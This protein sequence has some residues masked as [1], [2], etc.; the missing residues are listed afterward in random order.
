MEETEQTQTQRCILTQE[1][2]ES[3]FETPQ[4]KAVTIGINF[5]L[6][7]FKLI[8]AII[9]QR[10]QNKLA[11]LVR[12]WVEYRFEVVTLWVCISS[13]MQHLADHMHEWCL[14]TACGYTR[15]VN[16]QTHILSTYNVQSKLLNM[17]K[18]KNNVVNFLKQV[19]HVSQLAK[20]GLS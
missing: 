2:F 11:R 18:E 3:F 16:S 10:G 7:E 5:N 13:S 15:K 12:L 17:N 1:C 4:R 6:R 9:L 8:M 19:E 20:Y 14:S